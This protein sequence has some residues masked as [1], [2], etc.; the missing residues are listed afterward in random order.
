MITEKQYLEYLIKQYQNLIYSIC[1]KSVGNPF[2][3]EDL[4]QE[5]FLSAYKNLSRFDG[6]YEK[7]W[8]SKIAVRKCL[9][10]LKAAGRR[11]FQQK[12]P[13]FPRFRTGN[14]LPKMNI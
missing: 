14:P 1:L 8:L 13:T 12:T 10:Y 3:A 5:V 9:D 2:D 11:V 4:T 6:N 7:A